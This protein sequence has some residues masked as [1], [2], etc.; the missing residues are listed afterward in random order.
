MEPEPLRTITDWFLTQVRTRAEHP[1]MYAPTADG[2]ERT[3]WRE[4]GQLARQFAAYL[5]S[6][7]VDEGSHVALWSGNR[8]EWHTASAAI[9][10]CRAVPVPVYV[11]FSAEQGAYVLDHSES[12]VVVVDGLA[13]LERVLAV[14]ER[15]P[16]LRRVVVVAG[17]S[18]PSSDGMVLPW[19]AALV[20]GAAALER[21]GTAADLE[22]RRASVQ[23]DDIAALIYTS[24]TTGPPK[25]VQLT[26]GNFA[27]EE[28]ALLSFFDAG[29][30]DRILS[31]LPLAHVLGLVTSQLLSFRHGNPVW[32][33]DSLD[34]LPERLREVRPTIFVGVPRVWEKMAAR[35]QHEVA[36]TAGLS[37]RVARWGLEVA[38]A[39]QRSREGGAEPAGWLELRRGLAD[40]LV[41]RRIRERT[42][43][44]SARHLASGAAPLS[45]ETLRF[46]A[47]LG[48]EI[49]EGY[50]LSETSAMATVNPPGRVRLGTVGRPAADVELQLAPDGEILIRGPI[51]S[52]GYYKEQAATA[53]ALDAEGWFHS[54]DLGELDDAG[55]LRITGRKKDLIIT[56]GGKN[57]APAIIE[58][59]LTEH[60]LLSQAVCIGDRRPY[61][62][63]L[64]TVD[65]EEL[66]RWAAERRL[67]GASAELIE[68]RELHDEISDWV[69]R[70]NQGFSR[71][72][73]VKR[74]RI[75]T[76]DF[77]VGRELTPTLKVRRNVVSDL[78]AAE[79]RSLYEEALA[80]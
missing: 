15:L 50:G 22:R 7:G 6:E 45:P 21:E 12:R 60:L 39:A 67:G 40:R 41:L 76:R 28:A 63:A 47:S 3:T 16:H 5:L 58:G 19:S 71:P 20:A 56:A 27:A 46:L 25:G 42:G 38:Q 80:G 73:Q 24:G 68:S 36:E 77:E 57:V 65:A 8:P 66:R 14:R 31:Y 62:S 44:D 30:D 29:P 48:M 33:L 54:G 69:E 37:G 49:T 34:R 4:L 55:Y 17:V 11:T 35:I 74:W 9:W 79:I 32:F 78:Y 2:W 43:L 1:S 10:L 75:L 72:E 52:V 13:T 18:Q 53:E 70:V 59:R 23:L 61:V 26:H 51:V 64:L